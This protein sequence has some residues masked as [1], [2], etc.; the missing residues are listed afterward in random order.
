MTFKF[1]K[2]SVNVMKNIKFFNFKH[3]LKKNNSL[4]FLVDHEKLTF[5][6][7]ICASNKTVFKN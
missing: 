5:P 6:K 4:K 1:L 3:T 7:E 2:E